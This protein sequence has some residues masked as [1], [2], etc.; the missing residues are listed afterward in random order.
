MLFLILAV[1]S[2]FPEAHTGCDRLSRHQCGDHHSGVHRRV[3]LLRREPQ[4]QETAGYGDH[5]AGACA[6]ERLTDR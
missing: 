5:P 1:A 2:S 3:P 6:F 4:P